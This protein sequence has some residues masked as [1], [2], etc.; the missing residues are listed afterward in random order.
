[1]Q[2]RR[3]TSWRRTTGAADKRLSF[4]KEMLHFKGVHSHGRDVNKSINFF[5][6]T[7][8]AG[9][10]TPQ[11]LRVEQ[12]RAERQIGGFSSG[13]GSTA[14]L[15]DGERQS[16]G[17]AVGNGWERHANDD[18]VELREALAASLST[19]GPCACRKH[20]CACHACLHFVASQCMDSPCDC[21]TQHL[22]TKN[23]FAG[24]GGSKPAPVPLRPGT[25]PDPVL[26]VAFAF[27]KASC[28]SYISA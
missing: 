2:I 13:P 17:A 1:M 8:P 10:A 4:Q 16:G 25:E 9:I 22:I 15:D 7:G 11:Q 5:L 27:S 24:G 18:D 12:E 3:N 26:F 14:S 28:A 21:C 6:E 20:G 19:G 23:I